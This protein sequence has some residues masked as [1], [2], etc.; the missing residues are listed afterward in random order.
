[1]LEYFFPDLSFL[2]FEGS[3]PLRCTQTVYVPVGLTWVAGYWPNTTALLCFSSFSFLAARWKINVFIIIILNVFILQELCNKVF[4]HSSK[5]PSAS[6]SSRHCLWM[7]PTWGFIYTPA[8]A[9]PSEEN[10]LRLLS[11]SP[12]LLYF[13]NI[14][15]IFRQTSEISDFFLLL[16]TV[17]LLSDVVW[18]QLGTVLVLLCKLAFRIR[19]ILI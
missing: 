16:L 12:S 2:S 8:Q 6:F 17:L 7:F 5:L 3:F 10:S 1:M 15:Y 19:Q 11:S 18:G 4:E 14:A 13:S 9:L